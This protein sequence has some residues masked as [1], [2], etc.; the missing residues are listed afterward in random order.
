LPC[1][2]FEAGRLEASGEAS[3]SSALWLAAGATFLGGYKLSRNS[4]L[5][6]EVPVRVPLERHRVRLGGATV[7]HELPAIDVRA[8]FGF[9]ATWP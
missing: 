1:V 2:D 4:A 5:L 7:V 3:R 6:L 8:V 9:E